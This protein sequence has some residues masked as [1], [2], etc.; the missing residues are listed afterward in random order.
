MKKLK[1]TR[2]VLI[3]IVVVLFATEMAALGLFL[4]F[5]CKQRNSRSLEAKESS[6]DHM[7]SS[8]E[9]KAKENA[10]E[11]DAAAEIETESRKEISARA[12]KSDWVS[13]YSEYLKNHYLDG[14]QVTFLFVNDDDIPEMLLS[15][16]ERYSRVFVTTDGETLS[17]YELNGSLE[18]G[19]CYAPGTGMIY[20]NTGTNTSYRDSVVSIEGGHWKEIFDGSYTE[21]QRYEEESAKIRS[22]GFYVYGIKDPVTG[23]ESVSG[24]EYYNRLHEVFP[25]DKAIR[26]NYECSFPPLGLSGFLSADELA[27]YF[28]EILDGKLSLEDIITIPDKRGT[29]VEPLPPKHFNI[30][31]RMVE[32]PFSAG[33]FQFGDMVFQGNA[34][35]S[36]Q[37]VKDVIDTSVCGLEYEEYFVDGREDQM[38]IRV[39]DQSGNEPFIFKWIMS[40]EE[41]NFGEI[42]MLYLVYA[43]FNESCDAYDDA[44]VYYGPFQVNTPHAIF[45][46]YPGQ[47]SYDGKSITPEALREYMKEQ[48]AIELAYGGGSPSTHQLSGPL[49]YSGNKD[50]SYIYFTDYEYA[51]T[52]TKGD[53]G[54]VFTLNY[55]FGWTYYG[56]AIRRE[57]Y[58]EGF[59]SR[60]A[61]EEKRSQ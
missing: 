14:Y 47:S 15:N 17:D 3:T 44:S 40:N 5:S 11:R 35:M 19:E 20:Y 29:E 53:N 16:T 43:S 55:S 32:E 54:F 24:K 2:K 7:N 59:V 28:E 58:H 30:F 42:G 60:V 10:I 46:R 26:F 8:A 12:E 34:H 38:G 57:L 33:L 48:S 52:I 21:Q 9:V 22:Y 41:H 18:Y 25:E 1:K 4:G 13:Q 23:Y 37:D 61:I 39:H 56:G 31:R 51:D 27:N 49:E 6:S 50:I 36:V 45:A